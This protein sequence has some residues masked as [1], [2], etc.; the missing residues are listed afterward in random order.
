MSDI[1]SPG[2][3]VT[4]NE[5]LAQDHSGKLLD[6]VLS[7]LSVAAT[8]IESALRTDSS[9]MNKRV[10]G[11]LLTAIRLGESLVTETWNSIHA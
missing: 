6:E 5:Q 11:D 8:T 2:P 9:A 10:L 4:L 7:E 1:D 3:V